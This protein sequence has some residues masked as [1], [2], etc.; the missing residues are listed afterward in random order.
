MFAVFEVMST[1]KFAGITL[2]TTEVVCVHPALPVM[3][4]VY[5]VVVVGLTVGFAEF[6]GV[7]FVQL[8]VGLLPKLFP[9]VMPVPRA[10]EL[11]EQMVNGPPGVTVH[12]P[13][14][15]DFNPLN[16]TNNNVKTIGF[17]PNRLRRN[18]D[19]FN[20]DGVEAKFLVFSLW[21]KYSQ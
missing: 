1:P 9:K 12:C 15:R 5:V 7:A 6:A 16:V 21:C 2:T 10:M 13:S 11:P 18:D 3:V 19:S 20:R 14:I 17:N 4:T 8:Y